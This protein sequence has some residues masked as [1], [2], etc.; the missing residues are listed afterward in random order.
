[1]TVININVKS[2]AHYRRLRQDI[3]TFL[4]LRRQ[5]KKYG[6]RRAA[7]LAGISPDE[8]D[9]IETGKRNLRISSIIKLLGFYQTELTI[10]FVDKEKMIPIIDAR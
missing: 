6:L 5:Q 7:V 3:G 9:N 1:M 2:K 10:K 4:F 8:L